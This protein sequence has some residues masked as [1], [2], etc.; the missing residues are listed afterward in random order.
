MI[1]LLPDRRLRLA[2]FGTPE[3]AR[4][5]L[6]ALLDADDDDVVLVVSQP[7][8]PKGR[9]KQLE[10]TPTKQ[11]A[12]ARGIPVVQPEKMRDGVLTQRLLADR[13]DLAIVAAFGRI[14]PADMLEAP[15][16]GCWNVHASLLPR[17]RG[18]S[19]IQHA[20]LEGDA[21]TGVTLM[22]MSLGLDEGPMLKV[23]RLPLDGHETTRTL[24]EKLAALGG[25]L[26]VEALREAK[27]TGLEVVIQ[28]HAAHTLA[29]IIH[30]E[31]GKLD[32]RA[33]AKVLERRIRGLDP[34][35]GTWITL[36]G[37]EVLK[38]LTASVG[39]GSPDARPGQVIQL[40][41]TLDVQTGDGALCLEI[42]QP[43]GK[44]PMPTA[45]YLRGAGR[46]LVRGSI[47]PLP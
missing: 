39:P 6:Q 47:L 11:L 14:L 26:T 2:Y 40:G 34:W 9:G 46:A 28:D 24:T 29:P 5:V 18:A 3:I 33:P 4:S 27:K 36:D 23:A 22:K 16:Y 44:K 42:V 25:Q 30:K 17:F 38:V 20:I 41:A 19:P 10:P 12:E 37:G 21:E 8:R 13:I 31:A 15:P 32:L 35:P 7:D 45:D 1:A 43:A